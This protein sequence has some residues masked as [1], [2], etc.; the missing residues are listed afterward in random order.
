[1]VYQFIPPH[2]CVTVARWCYIDPSVPPPSCPTA[3]R[4][5]PL[6]S[7]VARKNRAMVGRGIYAW[8]PFAVFALSCCCN[9]LRE[10]CFVCVCAYGCRWLCM[11][12]RV[13]GCHV[14]LY[15]CE[16]GRV[17]VCVHFVYLCCVYLRA[18]RVF[19][20]FTCMGVFICTRYAFV[21]LV[22]ERVILY[23]YASS[24]ACVCACV[25][26]R[27]RPYLACVSFVPPF[28]FWQFGS[29]KDALAQRRTLKNKAAATVALLSPRVPRG[30]ATLSFVSAHLVVH[31][32]CLLCTSPSP[33]D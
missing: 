23:C 27:L 26:L 5:P 11:C 24:R 12:L 32:A 29:S 30:R 4:P 16:Y 3:S 13:Y 2:R 14:R 28:T 31:R 17:Y 22:C 7:H 10:S 21:I 20:V 25:C 15:V 33:R 9:V 6:V 19:F 8:Y 18:L 1:M